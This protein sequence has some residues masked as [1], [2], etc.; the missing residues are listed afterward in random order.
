MTTLLLGVPEFVTPSGPKE[1]DEGSYSEEAYR[2][3]L[4]AFIA[5]VQSYE[6]LPRCGRT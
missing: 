1:G 4:K 2:A 5:E 3:Q 6:K